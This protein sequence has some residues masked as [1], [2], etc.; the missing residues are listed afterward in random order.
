MVLHPIGDA[1]I[2]HQNC[3]MKGLKNVLENIELTDRNRILLM[4][5]LVDCGIKTA[6]GASTYEQTMSPNDQLNTIVELFKPFAKRGM[7]DGCVMGNHE[8][9]I[10]KESGIDILEQFCNQLYIPYFLYSGVITYS[11]TNGG[12][13]KAYNVNMF[14]GKSGGSVENALR[15]CKAMSNKVMADIYLMGHCHHKAHTTRI[16]KYVD[17]RNQKIVDHLQY[18]VLTGQMLKYDD[19]YADQANLEIAESG[20]PIVT[21]QTKERRI[22]VR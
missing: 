19:S 1:H 4:G 16:M 8:Y 10:F 22:V 5:D 7:I 3:D 21:L 11:L 13:T 2:G 12:H 17:S 6:I 14:H 9:R 15:A 20:F 18:F